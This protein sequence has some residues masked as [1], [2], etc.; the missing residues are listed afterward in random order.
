M[1]TELKVGIFVIIGLSLLGY[2][3]LKSE[4]LPWVKEEGY[5][6][7]VEFSHI[8]GL[9]ADA[10][11]R[12]AGYKVGRV[13]DM[14]LTDGG[15]VEVSLIINPAVR[16]YS[17]AQA[18]VS[19]IGVLGEKYIEISSG[20]STNPP[21]L[22]GGQIEGLAPTSLDQV[23]AVINSIG[24][25]IDATVRYVQEVIGS[26][27]SQ[28]GVRQFFATWEELSSTMRELTS[29]NK[30]KINQSFDN[31]VLLTDGLRKQIPQVVENIRNSSQN[32]D[33]MI[34]ENRADLREG[35]TNIKSVGEELDESLKTLN[36]ILSKIKRGEGTVGG[37]IY[38]DEVRDEVKSTIRHVSQTAGEVRKI[39]RGFGSLDLMLGFKTD[40]YFDSS[41]FKTYFGLGLR[42]QGD[43]LFLLELIDDQVGRRMTTTRE[44]ETIDPTGAVF[45]SQVKTTTMEKGFLMSAQIGQRLSR[46]LLRGGLIES[47]FGAGLDL[48]VARERMSFSIDTF[49]FGRENNP[50]C[51]FRVNFYP[52]GGFFLSGGYDDFLNKENR[53]LL[54]GVGYRF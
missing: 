17:D 8:A 2:L 42:T 1:R 9:E 11:V 31:M 14:R 20:T 23:V 43:R 16:I 39:V 34:E 15:T 48:I 47:E 6:V 30:E 27:E 41:N 33:S 40:Y 3:L 44:M 4:N 35:I 25:E 54:F 28:R 22:D 53:Q 37:L 5:L 32:I 7:R 51:R 46:W 38:D 12:L 13:S 26:E 52:Y 19:T 10:D 50:H 45:S 24:A 21:V 18:A 49:N 29:T 36:E